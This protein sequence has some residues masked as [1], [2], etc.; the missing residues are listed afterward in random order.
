[1]ARK[2]ISLQRRHFELMAEVLRFADRSEDG[3]TYNVERLHQDFADTLAGTNGQF[4]R[5]C[6]LRACNGE[7]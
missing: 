5:D 6:F 7:G 2:P 3:A 1:M 4:D